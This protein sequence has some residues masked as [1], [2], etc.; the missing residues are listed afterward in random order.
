MLVKQKKEIC[1]FKPPRT[2]PTENDDEYT[3]Y[4]SRNNM[5]ANRSNNTLSSPLHPLGQICHANKCRLLHAKGILRRLMLCSPGKNMCLGCANKAS[6]HRRIQQIELEILGNCSPN[7]TWKEVFQLVIS[8]TPTSLKHLRRLMQHIPT[9]VSTKR[10]DHI[11]GATRYLAN[12][13]GIM[14]I[15]HSNSD[16]V[17]Q[18]MSAIDRKQLWRIATFHCRCNPNTTLNN[19]IWGPRTFCRTCNLLIQVER[20]IGIKK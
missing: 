16:L 3:N 12:S 5:M 8:S 10:D 7:E 11:F 1:D 18:S 19:Q 2:E 9:F 20:N 15:D 13:L 4:A 14:L 6:R 17:D